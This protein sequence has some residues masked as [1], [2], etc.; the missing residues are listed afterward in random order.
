MLFLLLIHKFDC[1]NLGLSIQYNQLNCYCYFSNKDSIK[2]LSEFEGIADLIFIDSS[3]TFV[4]TTNELYEAIGKLAPDGYILMHDVI[5]VPDVR[6]AIH[7]IMEVY[8]DEFKYF[9]LKTECG[10]GV[11]QRK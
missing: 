9:I 11:L 8:K 7:H 4:Q 5:S 6:A 1:L 3:H 10:L 2:F